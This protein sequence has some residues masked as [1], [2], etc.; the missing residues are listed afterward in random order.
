MIHANAS[1]LKHRNGKYVVWQKTIYKEQQ[2]IRRKYAAVLFQAPN[3][4]VTREELDTI[5]LQNNMI[6]DNMF[7]TGNKRIVFT[8]VRAFISQPH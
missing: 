5:A 6:S 8:C 3:V 1:P 7:M 2:F 4:I